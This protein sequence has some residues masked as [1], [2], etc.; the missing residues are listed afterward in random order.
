MQTQSTA[1]P[2]NWRFWLAWIV[3]STLSFAIGWGLSGALGDV[4]GENIGGQV[5]HLFLHTLGMLVF[6]TLVAS[7]Q[8]LVL[9][10]LVPWA[11]R[12][13]LAGIVGYALG[14]LCYGSVIFLAAKAMP[15]VVAIYLSALVPMFGA[16]LAQGWAS[17]RFG[18]WTTGWVLGYLFSFWVAQAV[19]FVAVGGVEGLRDHTSG[20]LALRTLS[21][22]LN[23][24][25]SG[26]VGGLFFGI[27]SGSSL[28]WLMRRTSA[29]EPIR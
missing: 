25:P 14:F 18:D 27:L 12:W 28:A 4:V 22:T 19:A 7:S 21:Y 16:A 5:F 9:R 1:L 17:R 29:V 20:A 15:A 24:I 3:A 8:W 6:G 13:T 11:S 2:S 10:N 26:I 23:L